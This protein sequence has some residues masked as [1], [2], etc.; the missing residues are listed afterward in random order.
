MLTQFS[1]IPE[2]GS[3]IIT[4]T[5]LHFK[6]K[7]KT[8]MAT[9]GSDE[10]R[11]IC[12]KFTNAQN[13]TDVE[14]RNDPENDPFR[15]KYKARDL[16]REI[17]CSL[18]SFEAGDGEEENQGEGGEQRPTELPVDVQT[19][20]V[21]VQGLSG[22]SP[23]G[24][25]AAKLGA[26]EYYLGVNHVDTEELSAGQEHLMNCMKQLAKCRVSSENV[27]LFIHVRVTL[28]FSSQLTIV[29]SVSLAVNKLAVYPDIEVN[30]KLD[31]VIVIPGSCIDSLCCQN[32]LGILWAGRDETETAQGFLETAE[33]IYQRYM[34]EVWLVFFAIVSLK[35]LDL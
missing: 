28:T 14:S 9:L 2:D 25:R 30:A 5:Q 19:E 7:K 13:L 26:V 32:Q 21:F 34:K 20:D 23:A 17:Y 35:L 1:L 4:M 18:K 27:S 11:A 6:T 3:N 29:L 31:Q 12:D 22:D 24:M 15:S 8:N 10:W 16:L 33:S